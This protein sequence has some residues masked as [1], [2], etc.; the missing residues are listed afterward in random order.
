MEEK[1]DIKSSLK[2][3]PQ[4]VPTPKTSP[5]IA[6]ESRPTEK[7]KIKLK[8]TSSQSFGTISQPKDRDKGVFY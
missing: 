7:K 2:L 4:K 1:D 8:E 6:S 5:A 3:I